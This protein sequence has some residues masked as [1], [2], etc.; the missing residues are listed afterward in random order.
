MIISG[1]QKTTLIDYPSKI[2]CTIFLYGCNFR[3]GFCYNPD[4]VIHEAKEN[5]TEDEV[6]KFLEKRVGKL[7]GVCITG[8]E[9][10]I[11]VDKDFL[12]KIKAMGYA[13]KID[14]NGSFPEK[15]LEFIDEKL[16]DYIAM[17][18]KASKENYGKVAGVDADMAKIERSIKLI[19]DFGNYEFRTTI[20]PSFHDFLEMEKIGKWMNGIC[21]EKLQKYFLQ[22]FK[23][24]NDFIDENFKKEKDAGEGYLR[25]LKEIAEKYFEKVEIRV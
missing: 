3:C 17:D 10:L 12:R 11:T 1:L 8:G 4:L 13:V 21:G 2:A 16:I 6:L 7:E 23:N 25:K 24:K 9:P 20:V 14:T 19:H 18:V 15:L 22:G 5:F